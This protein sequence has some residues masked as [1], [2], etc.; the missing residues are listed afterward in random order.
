MKEIM[1]AREIIPIEA[2]PTRMRF[3]LVDFDSKTY[4]LPNILACCYDLNFNDCSFR[5]SGNLNG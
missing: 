5:E 1:S 4:F 2:T 3:I